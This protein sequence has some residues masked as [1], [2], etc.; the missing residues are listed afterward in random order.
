MSCHCLCIINH[1]GQSVCTGEG[2]ETVVFSK[3]PDD[4]PLS[5]MGLDRV[6][7]TMCT[8]CKIETMAGQGE[9]ELR[10][11]TPSPAKSQ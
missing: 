6:G 7:V 5:Q 3:F 2:T 8:P 1:P 10:P 9:E 11:E 4:S